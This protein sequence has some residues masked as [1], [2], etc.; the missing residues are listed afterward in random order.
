MRRTRNV[1]STTRKRVVIDKTTRLR[2]VLVRPF[3][4]AESEMENWL[5][6]KWT[7]WA[8][9]PWVARGEV[10][11]A[12]Q[13]C[14]RLVQS[15]LKADNSTSFLQ[16]ELPELAT[17]FTVQWVAVWKRAPEWELVTECGR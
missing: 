4:P 14:D 12:V 7:T 6:T 16:A 11:T 15:A 3:T 2:V 8:E 10:G 17:E 1:L 9:L 5:T 13:L